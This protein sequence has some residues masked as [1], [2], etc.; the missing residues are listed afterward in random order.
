MFIYYKLQKINLGSF[1]TYDDAL[2]I[3]NKA[4]KHFI[5]NFNIL[6]FNGGKYEQKNTCKY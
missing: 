4:E 6:K 1:N 3:R 5:M 2:E